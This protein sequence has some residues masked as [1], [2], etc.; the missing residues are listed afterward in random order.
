M[1]KK[2]TLVAIIVVTTI[3]SADD[4]QE[5]PTLLDA[6]NNDSMEMVTVEKQHETPNNNI[7]MSAIID[8]KTDCNKEREAKMQIDTVSYYNYDGMS[9]FPVTVRTQ[10]IQGEN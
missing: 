2:I 1:L 6:P 7:E 8:T 9:S 3:L 10:D 4:Y 5:M